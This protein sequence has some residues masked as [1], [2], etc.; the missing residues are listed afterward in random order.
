MTALLGEESHV[1][2]LG[3]CASSIW[4]SIPHSNSI[5]MHLSMLTPTTPTG[6]SVGHSTSIDAKCVAKGGDW[7]GHLTIHVIVVI[8]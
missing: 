6:A 2:L 1:F 3:M 5:I 4:S 7:K 8:R